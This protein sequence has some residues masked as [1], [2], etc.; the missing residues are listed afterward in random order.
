MKDVDL[1]EDEG[2]L[3]E[4]GSGMETTT[5]AFDWSSSPVY[6]TSSLDLVALTPPL[7]PSTNQPSTADPNTLPTLA[8]PPTAP[9]AS[10]YISHS[11]VFLSSPI[12]SYHD[13]VMKMLKYQIIK[14]GF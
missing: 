6:E 3:Q 4:F 8:P 7:P 5:F 9:A 14:I 13:D 12:L 10:M 2:L 1:E 11:L